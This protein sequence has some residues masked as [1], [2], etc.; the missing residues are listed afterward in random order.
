MYF[1]NLL[2]VMCCSIAVFEMYGCI[3]LELYQGSSSVMLEYSFIEMLLGDSS[4]M[5]QHSSKE[6]LT[7]YYSRTLTRANLFHVGFRKP[8]PEYSSKFLFICYSVL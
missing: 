8:V 6:M 1:I 4:S 3:L 5:L 7:R 2:L